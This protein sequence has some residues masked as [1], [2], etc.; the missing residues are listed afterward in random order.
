MIPI[1]FFLVPPSLSTFG[2]HFQSNLFNGYNSSLCAVVVLLRKSGD[3][4]GDVNNYR[5]IFRLFLAKISE[6]LVN[7]HLRAFTDSLKLVQPQQSGFH[8]G[9]SIITAAVS[10]TYEIVSE[11]TILCCCL[12]CPLKSI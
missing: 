3:V 5:P 6:S 1:S 4:S 8:P 7:L 10:V 2:T 11:K 9:D 12:Y